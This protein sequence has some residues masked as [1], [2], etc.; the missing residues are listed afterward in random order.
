MA[1]LSQRD[2][3]SLDW[4]LR[5]KLAPSSW[6]HLPRVDLPSGWAGRNGVGVRKEQVVLQVPL[7][8]AALTKV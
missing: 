8:P 4:N 3:T 5:E 7:I 2:T 1:C 6:P